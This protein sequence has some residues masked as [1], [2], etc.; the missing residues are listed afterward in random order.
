MKIRIDANMNWSVP[1]AI[2]WI[3]ALEQF[4]LQFVEQ[5]VP[6]FDLAGMAQVGGRSRPRSQPTR[7][8]RACARRSS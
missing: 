2:K 6:D 7:A 5:P 4:D 8:A 3:R 1:A